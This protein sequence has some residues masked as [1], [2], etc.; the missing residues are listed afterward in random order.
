[1]L[2]FSYGTREVRVVFGDEALKLLP[3]EV[4]ALGKSRVVLVGTRGRSAAMATVRELLGA[5]VAGT[6]DQAVPHAPE[7]VVRAAQE[8][9]RGARADLLLA[10]GGGSATGV[11][12]AV[13]LELGVPVAAVPTT[14]SGS[15]M[16]AVWGR[17]E[18]DHKVTG[19][20]P[21]VAPVLVVYDP[22]LT[23]SLDRA[24]SASSGM[25]AVAHAM[26]ALYAPD[27][28][29][30]ASLFALQALRL[31]ASSLPRI[32]G[33]PRDPDARRDAL[34]GA[35]FAGCALDLTSMGM[36]HRLA[37]VLAGA[38]GLPHAL[39]HAVLL[40][41]VAA[42]M[43]TT[44]PA[45]MAQVAAALGAAD[46]ATGLNAL[47]Q[48]LGIRETLSSLGLEGKDVERAANLAAPHVSAEAAQAILA[49]AMNL[50]PGR[51]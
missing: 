14:Y 15:E 19:K 35:H 20:D 42:F 9:A 45:A 34:L 7:P 25:N 2:K 40:P 12:K 22:A 3:D 51:P 30:I 32:A 18:G 37:H 8:M 26:E 17:M 49:L 4:R 46:A 28:S 39:A 41:H 47:N 6:F 1:M 27:A 24:T 43:E 5:A 36:Q 33:R 29:D 50:V 23:L 13:A 16:T 44:A 10:L 38:F 11:A 31:L 21:R 48:K